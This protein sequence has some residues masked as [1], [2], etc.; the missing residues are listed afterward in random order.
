MEAKTKTLKSPWEIAIG[1]R[2]KPH[3]SPQM[4]M[5]QRVNPLHLVKKRP[6]KLPY[7]PNSSTSTPE[8]HHMEC[9]PQI[10]RRYCRTIMQ[11]SNSILRSIG[12][13]LRNPVKQLLYI[14]HNTPYRLNRSVESRIC[15]LIHLVSKRWYRISIPNIQILCI[16]KLQSVSLV[17]P[18]RSI[19][20]LWIFNLIRTHHLQSPDR[21]IMGL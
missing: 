11:P 7:R 4:I 16:I 9:F 5:Y 12:I 19:P 21:N 13:N 14:A 8:I 1:T 17:I 15:R 10:K 18:P 6:H 3:F 20:H 2:S